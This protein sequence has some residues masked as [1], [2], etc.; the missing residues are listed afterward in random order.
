MKV[1]FFA[2]C[3]EWMGRREVEIPVPSPLPLID[4]IRREPEFAPLL[5][6][7]D[8]LKVAVNLKISGVDRIV[9]NGDEI[10]FFPPVSGG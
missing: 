3:A 7:L 6:R 5:E 2:G 9:G 4:L 10:A 8:V 1:L